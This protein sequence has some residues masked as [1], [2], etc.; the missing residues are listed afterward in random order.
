VTDIIFADDSRE[1][2]SDV[3]SIPPQQHDH[4]DRGGPARCAGARLVV[5]ALSG[6]WPAGRPVAVGAIRADRLR[7]AISAGVRRTDN[8]PN[9][10]PDRISP[11]VTVTELTEAAS[12]ER[13]M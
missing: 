5:V 2:D 4:G 10:G 8:D 13:A 6:W 7:A 1:G 3:R 12:L 9:R 11:R